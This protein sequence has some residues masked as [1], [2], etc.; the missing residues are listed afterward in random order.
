MGGPH[1]RA[2]DD[3]TK[4]GAAGLLLAL[5]PAWGSCARPCPPFCSADL[6][7]D[8]Q[9]GIGDLLMLLANWS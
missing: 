1:D 5:L 7:E 8:C 6:D 9:V 2:K 4:P 3:R